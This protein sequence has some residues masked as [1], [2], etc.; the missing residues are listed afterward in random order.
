ME[1]HKIY[2]VLRLEEQCNRDY[3]AGRRIR[4][5]MYDTMPKRPDF[6]NFKSTIC[7]RVKDMGDI[8]FLL[9]AI[10]T[11]EVMKLYEWKWYP[12]C[13]YLLA[14][15]DYISRLN[16]LPVCSDYDSLRLGKLDEVIY[17][18]DILILD[19]LDKSENIKKEAWEKAIPEFK[20]F[21][22]VES[23]VRNVV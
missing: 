3:N 4:K 5:M 1:I 18:A 10:E 13:L 21:N 15:I 11:D 9:D 23:E 14:M 7:H 20:R 17:P 8:A 2:L 12:E 6:E 16:D 22:I 19:E